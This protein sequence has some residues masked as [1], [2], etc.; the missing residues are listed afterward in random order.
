VTENLIRARNAIQGLRH[1]MIEFAIL[2]S[3][4]ETIE[5]IREWSNEAL[6]VQKCLEDEA[7]LRD[8]TR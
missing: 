3:E 5:K 2:A 8:V 6:A 7:D 4:E 1:S